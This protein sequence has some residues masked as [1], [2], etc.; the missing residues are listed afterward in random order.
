VVSQ[1][2]R[3]AG[4]K[5]QLKASPVKEL[6]VE[7]N[8]PIITPESI[9]KPET[10]EE[11]RSYKAEIGVV[12]AFGQLLKQ[13]LL[14]LFPRGCVN[15]H[16]SILP[17]WRGAAPI[18]RTLTEGDTEAGVALQK[19]VL[20]L[21]AGDVIGIR[22]FPLDPD[23]D[24]VELYEKL[25]NLGASLLEVELMDY[26]RGNLFPEAQDESKI[27]IAKKI[28]K[29]EGLIHWSEDAE[30]IYNK[31]RGLKMWPG[32]WTKRFDKTLKIQKMGRNDL[33]SKGEPGKVIR[34]EKDHC[35]VQCGKGSLKIYEVQPESKAKM[36]FESYNAGKPL[37]E[38]ET[39]G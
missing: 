39:L 26:V 20:A 30:I 38:G 24:A 14:D 36:S 4:R 32:V 5:M 17:R 15:I 34:V 22:K 11:L 27:T 6:A 37:S 19:I 8:I 21:D 16:G 29:E 13:E 25:K 7:N 1:P 31:Y 35:V 9:N 18:Q 3:P 28:K 23:M 10:L 12:V 33:D 2:D